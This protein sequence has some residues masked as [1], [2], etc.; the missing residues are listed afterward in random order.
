MYSWCTN[1]QHAPPPS[2]AFTWS[3]TRPCYQETFCTFLCKVYAVQ[4]QQTSRLVEE[5]SSAIFQPH[6]VQMSATACQ[7]S[8]IPRKRHF[9]SMHPCLILLAP[10]PRNPASLASRRLTAKV[11]EGCRWRP[12]GNDCPRCPRSMGETRMCRPYS[13]CRRAPTMFGHPL[14][15]G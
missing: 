11:L 14:C 10:V 6:R 9:C 15:S 13:K 4:A 12:P 2:A 8:P 1:S 5:L 3:Q 7:S